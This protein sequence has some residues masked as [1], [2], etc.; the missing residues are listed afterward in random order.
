LGSG[1]WGCIGQRS[2]KRPFRFVRF[3]GR[4]EFRTSE[5]VL[6]VRQSRH[7]SVDH[8]AFESRKSP[9]LS[10]KLDNSFHCDLDAF[11]LPWIS[12]MLDCVDNLLNDS[13]CS[14]ID[15]LLSTAA[16]KCRKQCLLA[17]DSLL[18]CALVA[19]M[20]THRE[21]KRVRLIVAAA[22]TEQEGT[23]DA[24]RDQFRDRVCHIGRSHLSKTTLDVAKES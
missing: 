24:I 17:P 1:H 20:V 13:A 10:G 11:L 19:Y 2:D 14:S 7:C 4:P 8:L 12:K 23:E 22:E 3:V 21:K 18:A 6:F 15:S 5:W 16:S 9:G